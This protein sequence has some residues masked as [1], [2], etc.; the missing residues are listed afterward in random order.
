[1]ATLLALSERIGLDS[2]CGSCA[3]VEEG[4]YC[5]QFTE[6]QRKVEEKHNSCGSLR[7][8]EEE[9]EDHSE[10]SLSWRKVQGL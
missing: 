2:S 10:D 7:Q 8:L 3:T 6:L 4:V 5:E 1:M 9:E